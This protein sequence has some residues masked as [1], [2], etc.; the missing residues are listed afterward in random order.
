MEINSN[1]VKQIMLIVSAGAQELYPGDV[2]K[3][4]VHINES[5]GTLLKVMGKTDYE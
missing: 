2:V 3:Q 1:D 4:A 5:Y